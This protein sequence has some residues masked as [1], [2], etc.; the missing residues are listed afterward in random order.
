MTRLGS[1]ILTVALLAAMLPSLTG[2][3]RLLPIAAVASHPAACHHHGV[4]APASQ[5][6]SYQCCV[7]GHHSVVITDSFSPR[8]PQ[9]QA[10][11]TSGAMRMHPATNADAGFSIAIFSAYSPPGFSLLRI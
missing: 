6:V 1:R 9:R 5:P 2:A 11:E 7:A 8:P 3:V 4:P 10:L